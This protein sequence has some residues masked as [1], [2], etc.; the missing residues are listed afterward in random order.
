MAKENERTVTGMDEYIEREA[1]IES[2][3][4]QPPDAHYPHWYADKIKALPAANVAPVMH[5]RC[6]VCSGKAV[7]TQDT[8][9]G[10]SLE[11]DSEQKEA[12]L[13][14]GDECL[15]AFHIDYC[16]NCGARMD[17]V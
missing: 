8:D 2:I 16:P 12:S 5:R 11:I 7:L 15:A 6:D 4:S 17:G 3:M 9:N 14:Y 13:W 10:Y 1:A